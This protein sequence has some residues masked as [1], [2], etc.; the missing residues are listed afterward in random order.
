MTRITPP[1]PVEQIALLTDLAAAMTTAALRTVRPAEKAH[2]VDL[3]HQCDAM[4]ARIRVALN[5]AE[6]NGP[7][8]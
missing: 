3:A 7:R 8:Q 5:G 1:D 4:A 2:F 6:L